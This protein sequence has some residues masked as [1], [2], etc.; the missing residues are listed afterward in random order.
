[1]TWCGIQKWL[2]AVKGNTCRFILALWRPHMREGP[3]GPAD[4]L[5]QRL[6]VMLMMMIMIGDAQG[7]GDAVLGHVTGQRGGPLHAR[8]V[9]YRPR[10]ACTI[11]GRQVGP[12]ER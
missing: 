7:R 1:M 2:S 8:A 5:P 9:P 6:I 4:G 12:C 11:R 3:C 10:R